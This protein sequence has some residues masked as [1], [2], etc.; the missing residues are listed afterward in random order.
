MQCADG[1]FKKFDDTGERYII[2][3]D[4]E[5][6]AIGQVYDGGGDWP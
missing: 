6:N 4:A 1:F 5:R 2:L 3:C